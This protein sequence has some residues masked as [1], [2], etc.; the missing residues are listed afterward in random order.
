MQVGLEEVH[1]LIGRQAPRE[2]RID[3]LTCDVAHKHVG[4][5]IAQMH[6]Q[7]QQGL[8][9]PRACDRK[10]RQCVRLARRSRCRR[11]PR[12]RHELV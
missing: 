10:R 12:V 9:K 11:R 2:S 3:A 6:K 1:N 7:R 5:S 8:L 4:K